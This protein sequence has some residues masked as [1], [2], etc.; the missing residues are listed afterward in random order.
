[1][2]PKSILVT[3]DSR[4]KTFDQRLPHICEYMDL[5]VNIETL[6]LSGVSIESAA[7]DTLY[8]LNGRMVD[9]IILLAGV[10]NLSVKHTNGHITPRYTEIGNLVDTMT[11][12]YTNAKKDLYKAAP[13]IIIGHL[14]GLSFLDYN[15]YHDPYYEGSD[16]YNQQQVVNNGL[17]YLNQAITLMNTDSGLVSPWLMDTVHTLSHGVRYN[18]YLRFFDGIH[19]TPKTEDLWARLIARAIKTNLELI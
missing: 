19:P 13:N 4:G 10:N 6:I 7:D 1:M 15:K 5:N 14:T 8:Y 16:Y 12:H 11:D 3:M 2:L 9:L 17:I 18:K